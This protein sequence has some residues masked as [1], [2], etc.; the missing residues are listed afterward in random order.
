MEQRCFRPQLR[1]I[2]TA[3]SDR[4]TRDVLLDVVHPFARAL[5]EHRLYVRL[6]VRE[7]PTHPHVAAR[8]AQ[9]QQD[10]LGLRT[11]FLEARVRAGD[12]R[13]HD[14]E[15]AGRLLTFAAMTPYRIGGDT[16]PAARFL[17]AA[18]D[19]VL[20]G[21]ARGGSAPDKHGDSPEAPRPQGAPIEGEGS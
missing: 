16:E 11:E 19:I 10:G 5:Y 18:V 13:P 17:A 1:G 6:L 8:L 3:G 20:R 12:L 15:S 14:A 2:L 7:A 4:P 9:A 21:I